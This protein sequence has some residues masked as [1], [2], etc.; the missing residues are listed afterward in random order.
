M[1]MTRYYEFYRSLMGTP[2]TTFFNGDDSL[3]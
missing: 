2:F 3:L 1:G